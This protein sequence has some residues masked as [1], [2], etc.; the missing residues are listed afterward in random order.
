MSDSRTVYSPESLVRPPILSK[1]SAASRG[2][3][4]RPKRMSRVT[5]MR[6]CPSWSAILF[7]SVGVDP[8][9][10]HRH[11]RGGHVRSKG[12]NGHPA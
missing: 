7:A 1:I 10:A 5:L 3:C 6:F 4:F 12:P 2:A 11:P 9:L 8:L